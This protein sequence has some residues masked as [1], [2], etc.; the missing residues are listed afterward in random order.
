MYY[1]SL[2]DILG[3][4]PFK[5]RTNPNDGMHSEIKSRRT[6]HDVAQAIKAATGGDCSGREQVGTS[7]LRSSSLV[8]HVA[9]AAG[10]LEG[11]H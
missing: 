1:R 2:S 11:R 3:M 8:P 10:S 5:Y 7:T 4:C 6:K 9:S